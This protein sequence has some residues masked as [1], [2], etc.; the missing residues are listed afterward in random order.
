[1]KFSELWREL[2]D[3]R[4]DEHGVPETSCCKTGSQLSL[5]L[6]SHWPWERRAE[7]V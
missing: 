1:M 7:V 4:V 6:G 5:T 3:R 2:K